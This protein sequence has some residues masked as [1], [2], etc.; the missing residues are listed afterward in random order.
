MTIDGNEADRRTGRA[1]D[2]PSSGAFGNGSADPLGGPRAGAGTAQAA[3][4][5]GLDDADE[6]ALDALLNALQGNSPAC[7]GDAGLARLSETRLTRIERGARGRAD[8]SLR[9]VQSLARLLAQ[10]LL[11]EDRPP[12]TVD[13]A[14]AARHLGRLAADSARWSLLA[15]HATM[16]RTQ[17]SVAEEVARHWVLW[18]QYLREWPQPG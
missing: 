13:L 1:A 11:D 3:I 14:V 2:E 8:D 9:E 10:V 12:R 6:D 17:R 5:G 7:P 16:Y 15:E 4:D 18:A